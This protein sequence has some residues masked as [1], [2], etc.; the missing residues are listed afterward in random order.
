MLSILTE[1]L[2]QPGFAPSGLA[3]EQ[4]YPADRRADTS[5]YG[6]L[7][8][9]DPGTD[10]PPIEDLRPNDSADEGEEYEFV[11]GRSQL[12]AVSFLVLVLVCLFSGISYL[13]GRAAV[14]GNKEAAATVSAPA[15]T[16]AAPV[17]S[18][19]LV[20][21]PRGKSPAGSPA[22]ATVDVN[23]PLFSE[24]VAGAIY[25][26]TGAV[27]R[28]VAAIMA[29]GLRFHGFNAFVAAGPSEKVFRVLVGPFP[30]IDAYQRAKA[31]LENIGLSAF[32]QQY[33]K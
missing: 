30:S 24:P 33:H 27:E 4:P 7:A 28:G 31:T 29:E 21:A 12:A 6:S 3:S 1:P 11:L 5:V 15:A 13:A 2:T 18:A 25:I 23:A 26:Q 22:A 20:A 19:S 32:G 8:T 14:P 9:D 10:A 17:L 16:A